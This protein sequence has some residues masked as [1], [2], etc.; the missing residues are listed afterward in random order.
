MHC[1]TDVGIRLLQ[2]DNSNGSEALRSRIPRIILNTTDITSTAR[3]MKSTTIAALFNAVL[4]NANTSYIQY[5]QRHFMPYTR[6]ESET[7]DHESLKPP[8]NRIYSPP[9]LVRALWGDH[10]VACILVRLLDFH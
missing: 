2:Q 4:E 10:L 1:E 5:R 8:A 6:Y 7:A 3:T 9:P